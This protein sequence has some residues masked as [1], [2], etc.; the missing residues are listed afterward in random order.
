MSLRLWIRPVPA[1]LGTVLMGVGCVSV[2]KLKPHYVGLHDLP[3]Q[4]PDSDLSSYPSATDL[5]KLPDDGGG[6][7][8][9]G[10][11]ARGTRPPYRVGPLDQL[12][13]LVWGRPDLGSQVPISMNGQL[14]GSVVHEDGAMV[15][16]FLGPLPVAG[17][18]TEE[19]RI[20]VQ[21]R[22]SKLVENP[23]IDVTLHSCASQAVDVGGAVSKPGLYYL[24]A[25]RLT[26]GE[27]LSAAGEPTQSADQ[28]RGVLTRG[29]QAYRLDYREA[30]RG[31]SRVADILLQDGDTV[32]FPGLDER[33]VY[34]FGEVSRQGAFPIP[35]QGMTLLNALGEARGVDTG[36]YKT[37]GI[38]L[39]RRRGRNFVVYKLKMADILQGPEILMAAG[40][41]VFVALSGLDRW[42]R[43]WRKALP[44]TTFRTNVRVQPQP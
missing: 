8:S 32:F 4:R 12:V 44:F 20:Q 39:M 11:Q 3:V 36:S 43:W 35:E 15:L 21:S 27:L 1:L 26:V 30:E 31:G 23:Q 13:V 14:R 24:C 25:D 17:K 22:Y 29:G 28:A 34:V 16:P 6:S 40:D 5:P 19:I 38:F 7:D 41:R 2:P 37:G 42:E 10:N 9:G 18:T 33:E